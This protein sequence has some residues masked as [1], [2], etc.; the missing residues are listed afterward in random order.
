VAEACRTHGEK[1]NEI[2]IL[3]DKPEEAHGRPS[4]GWE[5]SN[6]IYPTDVGLYGMSLINLL[7]PSGNFT[8][9]QV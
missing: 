3:F 1:R 7:K 9:H 4:S 2:L 5:D 8:Y 6:I